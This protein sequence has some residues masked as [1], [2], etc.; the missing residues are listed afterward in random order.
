MQLYIIMFFVGMALC[1]YA[2]YR[3]DNKAILAEKRKQSIKTFN[4]EKVKREI[5]DTIEEQAS[6]SKKNKITVLCSQAGLKMGYGQYVLLCILSAIVF[7]MVL[8]SLLKNEYLLI[9][10]FVLGF[11][12]PSQVITFMRNRRMATLDKQIGSFLQIVTERYANTKDFPKS[13]KDCM[14]DFK[15]SEPLYSELLDTVMEIEL[16]VPTGEAIRN[17]SVRTGSKYVRRLGDY[18][19]LSIQIGTDDARSTLLKQAFLQYEENRT[20]TNSLKAALSGPSSEAYL[21]IAFIPLTMIYNTF[22]NPDYLPFMTTTQLGKIGVAGIFAVIIGSIWLVNTK[23]SAP[24][25]E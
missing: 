17:L 2:G 15:G 20:L 5:E 9:V 22:T 14:S 25:D 3:M 8:Y 18:Y 13:I 24:L 11:T 19:S 21:M 23:I 7:P 12:I 16:G 6:F 4:I 1:I 10:S